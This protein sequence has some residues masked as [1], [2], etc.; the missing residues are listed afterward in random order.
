M[1]ITLR[2]TKGSSLTIAELDANFIDLDGRVTALETIGGVDGVGVADIT[3]DGSQITFTMT[4]ATTYTFTFNGNGFSW[5]GEWQAAESY[6]VDDVVTVSGDGVYLVLKSHTADATFD[7]DELVS[8]SPAYALMLAESGGGGG[9]GGS[10]GGVSGAGALDA[11]PTGGTSGQVLT[12]DS[13]TDFDYS[14]QDATG[15]GT[16][17]RGALIVGSGTQPVSA[18]PYTDTTVTLSSTVY[19]TDSI[20]TGSNTLTV[21]SG[22]ATVRITAQV[23]VTG[24]ASGSTIYAFVYKNGAVAAGAPTSYSDGGTDGYIAMSMSSAVLEVSAGDD[25]TLVVHSDD[26]SVTLNTLRS[27]LG[28]EIVEGGG[29]GGG[30]G[31]AAFEGAILHRGGG[32]L[33]GDNDYTI[34]MD[35]IAVDSGGW[36]EAG[37]DSTYRVVVPG[38]TSDVL[39]CDVGFQV[40]LASAEAGAEYLCSLT[41]YGY[42]VAGGIPPR[43]TYYN[44]TTTTPVI[45]AQT[46]VTINGTTAFELRVRRTSGSADFNLTN[47][48]LSLW[49]IKRGVV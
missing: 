46:T 42:G 18:T 9:G 31:A 34:D 19:D 7:P 49:M 23:S 33:T 30:G 16:S 24:L 40:E 14:W 28:M 13:G 44:N 20:S 29:G 3:Q 36:T 5:R 38:S 11:V 45:G 12:K 22:V 26:A 15:G 6:V 41:Q 10:G 27:H 32:T 8:G 43:V 47:N 2:T 39:I 35:T 21:P 1:T 37:T 4:D 48:R 17:F 25:F